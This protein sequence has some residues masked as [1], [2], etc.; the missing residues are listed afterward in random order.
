MQ[1]PRHKHFF[2][3]DEY[4]AIERESTERHQY[5]D[6]Q[7]YDMAGESAAHADIAMNLS[8]VLGTQLKGT[9]CRARSKDTKVRSG[10]T[11]EGVRTTTGLYSYPDLVVICGEPEYHDEHEDVVLNPTVIVEVLSPSTGAFDHGDKKNRYQTWN[12][13]LTDYLLVAQDQP[14]VEHYH[15]QADRG[16]SFQTYTGLD[17]SVTLASI[18]C[19]L[20]LADVYD[21]IRFAAS[22]DGT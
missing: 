12:P 7:I 2:T 3:V 22:H 4:L 1:A 6:G 9:P 13:T 11:P 14:L 10:P 15:R 5:L 21:R 20:R 17:A 16:W 19:T 8:I 18:Q